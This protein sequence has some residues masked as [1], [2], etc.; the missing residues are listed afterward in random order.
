M[1]SHSGNGSLTDTFFEIDV[2]ILIEVVRLYI[3]VPFFPIEL[4]VTFSITDTLGAAI[5][6]VC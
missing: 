1:F 4:V 2:S 3:S 5:A 6:L